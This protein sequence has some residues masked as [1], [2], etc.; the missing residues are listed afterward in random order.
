MKK[1]VLLSV[2]ALFVFS[3]FAISVNAGILQIPYKINSKAPSTVP[4]VGANIGVT[5][6]E[7]FDFSP[8]TFETTDGTTAGSDHMEKLIIF[9]KKP[10]NFKKT[11][12]NYNLSIATNF[13]NPD[14]LFNVWFTAYCLDASK[15][16]PVLGLYSNPSYPA[17]YQAAAQATAAYQADQSDANLAALGAAAKEIID[18]MVTAAVANDTSMQSTISGRGL[19]GVT[20]TLEGDNYVSALQKAQTSVTAEI[21]A[22]VTAVILDGTSTSVTKTITFT[23][24][25]I[26]FDTYGVTNDVESKYSN[27]LWILE[28]S[29]PT[30]ELSRALEVAGVNAENLRTEVSTLSGVTNDEEL[31][32]TV[33][34]YVYSTIQYAV[35]KAVGAELENGKKLAGGITNATEL[36][37]LYTYLTNENH[38]GYGK[39]ADISTKIAVSGDTDKYKE[40]KDGFKFGPFTVSYKAPESAD[41]RLS[42]DKSIDGV[43]IVDASGTE[44]SSV[45]NGGKFYVISSKKAKIGNIKVNATTTVETFSP[46]TNR[47]KIYNPVYGEY[48]NAITGGLL[49]EVTINGSVDI[50]MNAKTGVE[51]VAIL[52]MVTLIAFSLGY[53]VL[54]YKTKP[55]ELS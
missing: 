13:G 12:E 37:K 42:L 30:L 3:V 1:K 26:A 11:G 29:Y 40:E 44:I 7:D 47:A 4:N 28:H 10:A 49:T 39:A 45:P 38:S 48:Q 33:E 35:W 18:L 54:S 15:A 52:L 8:V 27:A 50:L 9:E 32:K 43:K 31:T 41:V 55:V 24:F 21:T 53:I 25:E 23:P 5:V 14:N 6:S 19:D 17:K 22:N 36:N 20:Y 2:L 34:A 46:K 51:D 16:Y